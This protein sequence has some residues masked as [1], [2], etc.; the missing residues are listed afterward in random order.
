MDNIKRLV[1]NAWG[2]RSVTIVV[3]DWISVA[4]Q[5]RSCEW[6]VV[7]ASDFLGRVDSTV[8]TCNVTIVSGAGMTSRAWCITVVNNS[9]AVH[10][11][12]LH[13]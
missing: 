12:G 4:S 1:Q 7:S 13:Y 6:V 5:V 9:M 2:V 10:D 11:I 8:A 3:V